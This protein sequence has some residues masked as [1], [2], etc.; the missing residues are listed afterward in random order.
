MLITVYNPNW[1]NP[2][3][4][5]TKNPLKIMHWNLNSILAHNGA[6]ISILEAFN[7][8][9]S[10]DVIAITESALHN[11]IQNEV[12]Q[13]EGY[14]P[15]RRDLPDGITHGGVLL[16]HKESL[17]VCERPDL[18]TFTNMLVVEISVDDKKVIISVTY[19]QHHDSKLQL[20]CF[21]AKYKEMV[22]IVANEKPLCAVHIGDLNSR[23]S[24]WWPGDTDNDAGNYL[25]SVL[26]DTGLSQLVNKPT[27][28]IN[29]FKSCID[30]VITDQPNLINECSILPSL[31]STCHHC[32]N[33]IVLNVNNT[34][35][36]PYKRKIWHYERAQSSSIKKS[37]KQFDWESE[38]RAFERDPNL[39]VKLFT[40][41]LT[42][43][44]S[45]FIPNDERVIKPRE[46]AWVTRNLTH[47]YR[48]YKKAFKTFLKNGCPDNGSDRIDDLKAEYTKLV[49]DAKERYLV[50]QG[51]K[52]SQACDIQQIW[53]IIKNFLNKS[54]TTIIP[55]ILLNN[56]FVSD[57]QEKANLFNEFFAQQCTVLDTGSYIP[58]FSP[59]TSELLSEVPFDEDDIF[60]IL[61][62]LKPNKA[63]GWDGIS[64]RMIQMCGDTIISP[65][66][67]IYKN[68]LSKGVF[69]SLWKGANV[70]PVH[71][72][73][74]KNILG[75]YRPISLLP[76]FGKMFER[77]IFK[78]LYSYLISNKIITNKQSGFIKG[79]ST[80]NQLLS[81]THMIHSAFDCDIPK[82]VRSV[83]LDISKAFDKV[84]HE[85]LIFKLRQAGVRGDMLNILSDF[86]INRY[87]RTVINGKSSAWSPIQAGVPQGSVLGP[88]LFLLYINDL[89]DG[90]KSDARIFADDTSLFVVVDDPKSSYEILSHDLRLVEEW[91]KQWRMSF[92][93][94]PSKPPIEVV[95]STKTKPYIHLPLTFNGVSVEVKEEHKHLG[96]MLD[97]KLSFNSHINA[98]IKK[99]NKGVGAIRY[100][101]KYAPRSTL[102][103]IY[104]SYVRPQMEYCDVIFHESP[105]GDPL[106]TNK[107]ST[108]MNKIE[109]VQIQA[110]YAV[111]GAWKGTS[112]EKI[113]KELGW[114]CLSQRR[115]FRRMTLFYKI[116]NN[117]SPGYL[118]EC[119]TFPDPPWVSVY[120]R[121]PP[122]ANAMLLTPMVTRT[123]KFTSSFFPSCVTHWNRY[124]TYERHASNLNRFKTLL[125]ASF[126]PKRRDY[127]GVCD[128]VGL[129]YLTQ[130]RVDL[131][132]LRKYKYNH[133]FADTS[134]EFCL[135]HDGV[136]DVS[137]YL[138]DCHLLSVLRKTLLDNVSSLIGTNVNLFSRNKIINILLYGDKAFIGDVNSKILT[139]TIQYIHKSE[140]FKSTHD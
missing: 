104:K 46:P 118:T 79:D 58:A 24:E 17:A 78:S 40:D 105:L 77:V 35:P 96:L 31:H 139:Q 53:A 111:S 14:T 56:A 49:N 9:E 30:L 36:P 1:K 115:W 126:K 8:I 22:N 106:A 75:N 108:Q 69:P 86:L 101:S 47:A 122:T 135:C 32:I 102:E 99:A 15:I 130:L 110:A 43:I 66:A 10:Y 57:I 61:K 67:I 37:V 33:H 7:S 16:Y 52:L 68:C 12:I 129:R 113:Y 85:G 93:P 60:S 131:S 127:F 100:M 91:A 63:H 41:V 28:F 29:D 116:V 4:I 138:L 26:E 20:E 73:D 55:P 45:N 13:L 117:E 125:L 48:K 42:N 50:G 23:S 11:S 21:M 121:E 18:E 34:P 84:W 3:P 82:E 83:Y 80:T 51:A 64:V 74:K 44:F 87:Q 107:L 6:R 76:I 89:L 88:L 39:Q 98:C 19:R 72:K 136:E 124:L 128:I 94:D 137:H 2:G 120:G 5:I 59:I 90:M 25:I 54:K 27:H 109:S 38:L 62:T 95:F 140:K 70:V 92:N 65:L 81:I 133:N 134:D 123:I 132:P 119:I 114:E 97:K 71:K 103:Q 112:R